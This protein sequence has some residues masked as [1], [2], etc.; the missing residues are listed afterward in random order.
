MEFLMKRIIDHL[1]LEWKNKT[2]NRKPL[3]LRGARQVGKTHAAR[4]LGKT[5]SN[6]I[7]INFEKNK[8]AGAIF[9]YDL[10]PIRIMKAI[11]ELTNQP[12]QAGSTLLFFDEVQA[13]PNA[14]TAL[15]YF[16]ESVPE[17]HVIAAGSLVDFAIAQV[18]MPV[19][20]VSTLYMYPMSFMEFLVATNNSG[21]ARALLAH[22]HTDPLNDPLHDKLLRL[23]GT[24]L[25]IGG[26]PEAVF[27]WIQT[28]LSH[29][30]KEVHTE[31]LLTYKQDFE[32]YSKKHQLT[33]LNLLF[34][35]ALDQL[36]NKFMFSKVEGYQKRE[37]Y[38]ALELLEKAGLFY[39]VFKSSA[40]GIPIGAQ[41]DINHF[42]IIFFDV[43]LSQALLNFDITPWVLDVMP[44]FINKGQL[45][46]AFVGQ[47]ILAYSEPIKREQLYYWHKEARSSNAEVDYL[48]QIKEQVVPIE[49]KSGASSRAISMHM[50]LE[51]HPH[52]PYGLRFWT[53]QYAHENKLYSYP[54]YAIAKP[55][56]ETNDYMKNAIQ[57]LIE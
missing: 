47:E 14:I 4:E 46:E 28:S 39:P 50:F 55:L 44:S 20:R 57:W 31:L 13:V 18:G 36:G 3:L 29:A 21:W 12:I 27:A 8:P 48:I 33:Y 23:L 9:D 1:L 56:L 17:L 41:A 53:K 6:F 25:A 22:D 54:L 38:P 16:Y 10:D 30:V 49:V 35:N 52:S 45:V 26:M 15:R 5:F 37:L 2:F 32:K 43:G 40:Q 19:G 7:E 42:K 11:A 51:S 34:S 24:Y